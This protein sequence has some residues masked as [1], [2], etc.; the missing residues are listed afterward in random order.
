MIRAT[1]AGAF[2]AIAALAT[3]VP[4]PRLI[5]YECG[6]APSALGFTYTG[7]RLAHSESDYRAP[8]ARITALWR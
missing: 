8:C 2:L 6:D 7:P 1:L 4:M 3:L 5:G